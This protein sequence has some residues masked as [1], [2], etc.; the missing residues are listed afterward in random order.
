M[1]SRHDSENAERILYNMRPKE[2]VS[3]MSGQA[4]FTTAKTASCD[5]CINHKNTTKDPRPLVSERGKDGKRCDIVWARPSSPRPR[6]LMVPVGPPSWGLDGECWLDF[7]SLAQGLGMKTSCL[8]IAL[9]LNSKSMFHYAWSLLNKLAK[10]EKKCLLLFPRNHM[11][12]WGADL[13][14]TPKTVKMAFYV[15]QCKTPI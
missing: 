10:W 6:M 15:A 4:S 12:E 9:V 1:E 7:C 3:P 11:E 2:L 8:A 14:V 13:Q 5:I